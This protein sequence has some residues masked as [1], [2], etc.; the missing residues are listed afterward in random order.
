MLGIHA[1]TVYSSVKINTEYSP[2]IYNYGICVI[3]DSLVITDLRITS[4]IYVY[5]CE[6][7]ERMKIRL[8]FFAK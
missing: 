1:E 3:A 4:F 8:S 2:K 7:G 6:S 5:R